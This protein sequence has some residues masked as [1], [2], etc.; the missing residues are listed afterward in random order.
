[1]HDDIFK[2]IREEYSRDIFTTEELATI[3]INCGYSERQVSGIIREAIECHHVGVVSF[4]QL[5]R[6]PAKNRLVAIL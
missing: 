3:L 2:A 5:K 1:M 6:K 4:K